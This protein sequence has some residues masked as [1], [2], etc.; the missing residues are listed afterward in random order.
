MSTEQADISILF[1]RG[2]EAEGQEAE[3]L[4]SVAIAK[5]TQNYG[6]FVRGS[7]P[8]FSKLIC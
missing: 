4:L 8:F 6:T 1:T 3:R 5:I 7:K 2:L